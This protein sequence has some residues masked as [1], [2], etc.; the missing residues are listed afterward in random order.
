VSLRNGVKRGR[1]RKK[2]KKLLKKKG[3]GFQK[4][5]RSPNQDPRE[6]HRKP[7]NPGTRP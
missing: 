4:L 3:K 6:F 2:K 5:K 1:Q 7:R